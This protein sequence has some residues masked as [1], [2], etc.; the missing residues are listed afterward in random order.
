MNYITSDIERNMNNFLQLVSHKFTIPIDELN[1]L[2]YADVGTSVG[3]SQQPS[4]SVSLIKPKSSVVITETKKPVK[5]RKNEGDIVTC[6]HVIS[7]GGKNKRAGD[8][9][10]DKAK[11][12]YEF[13]SIHLKKHLI[14]EE[15]MAN[16]VAT[17][18]IPVPSS[19]IDGKPMFVKNLIIGGRFWHPP[20]KLVIDS[21]EN[22]LII[23]VF[24]NEKIEE[25]S[26]EDIEVCKKMNLNYKKKENIGI[27][28]PSPSLSN[29][30][31]VKKHK[32]DETKKSLIAQTHVYAK[33]VEDRIGDMLGINIAKDDE[34]EDDE[35][36][37][38][39][40]EFN[41]NLLD[42]NEESENGENED[43]GN[44]SEICENIEDGGEEEQYEEEE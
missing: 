32:A 37:E 9:C 8:A 22:K 5:E 12:G 42:E 40:D 18:P 23:G 2:F 6:K 28:R 41:E 27:K 30:S 13:C 7:R 38:D 36:V 39:G 14:E 17:K 44:I 35:F 24:K 33:H 19:E 21:P 10:G 15:L 29:I 31:S 43:N 34:V 20:T 11:K 4:S 26:D 3:N 25:L 1:E 16:V